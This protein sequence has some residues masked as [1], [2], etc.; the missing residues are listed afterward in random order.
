MRRLIATAL[1][2]I[3]VSL[4][5]CATKHPSDP[6][7]PYNRVV[8]AVNRTVD[9]ILVK[10]LAYGYSR[11]VPQPIKQGVLNVF[12]NILIVPTIGNDLL[13]GKGLWAI[14]DTSR[15]LINSTLGLGGILD[16][17]DPE[18]MPKRQNDFGLTLAHYGYENSMYFVLP[19]YGPSTIR[20]TIGRFGD[21]YISPWSYVE[22]KTAYWVARGLDV[23]ST[24]A[25]WLKHEKA[26]L[27]A[28]VDE[29]AL[30]R[31]AYL[32]KRNSHIKGEAAGESA[33]ADEAP[34]L[35]EPPL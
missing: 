3:A 27:A 16:I 31:D 29:Y 21:Q 34:I 5:G 19:I 20:D 17:A 25:E 33:P 8:Y 14:Q 9:K 22:P 30:V 12:D 1:C 18:C 11:V 23:L 7:E 24:R 28:A 2:I 26:F 10:P 32:Q 35:E 15:L 13:Q 6:L 4:T